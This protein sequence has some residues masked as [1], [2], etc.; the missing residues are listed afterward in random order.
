MLDPSAVPTSNPRPSGR[1]PRLAEPT[2]HVFLRHG[3][4]GDVWYAKYRL[5]DGQQK[6]KMLGPAWTE[7]GRPPAGYYTERTA[8]EALAAILADWLATTTP[9]R[10]DDADWG[11]VVA[12]EPRRRFRAVAA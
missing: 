7:R 6:Q 5:P 3:K 12:R 1:M 9:A 4:R 11:R 8:K 2:G 10:I